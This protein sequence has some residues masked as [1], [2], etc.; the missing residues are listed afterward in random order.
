MIKTSTA[1]LK[2]QYDYILVGRRRDSKKWS[3][4][5]GGKEANETPEQCI[6]REVQEE[7]GLY[8]LPDFFTLV[9][10]RM[11]NNDT[12]KVYIYEASV[13]NGVNVNFEF[14]IDQEFYETKWMSVRQILDWGSDLFHIPKDN[15]VVIDYL[16]RIYPDS[17]RKDE[18]D[19]DST[20]TEVVQDLLEVA[21]TDITPNGKADRDK[22][23]KAIEKIRKM[24]KRDDKIRKKIVDMIGSIKLDS[25]MVDDAETNLIS[26]ILK[27][28]TIEKV[29]MMM[30]FKKLDP[31]SKIKVLQEYK[32]V[33]K[34]EK[35]TTPLSITEATDIINKANSLEDMNY[36]TDEMIDSIQVA[37]D[38]ENVETTELLKALEDKMVLYG[39]DDE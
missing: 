5:G 1:I 14:D 11:V 37:I 32:E 35:I 10:T 23:N 20:K 17:V 28:E 19:I 38:D 12:V 39:I 8:I 33:L 26:R 22:R 4:I 21:L 13:P 27:A 6:S 7:V 30:E 15:N 29:K 2:D 24:V 25:I 34:S 3:F 9:D 18:V 36:F 31:I 16:K